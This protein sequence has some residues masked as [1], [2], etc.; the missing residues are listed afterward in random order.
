[1]RSPVPALKIAPAATSAPEAL[2][3]LRG[4]QAGVV[5]LR[6]RLIASFLAVSAA[7]WIVG[8]WR[9][10][11]WLLISVAAVNVAANGVAWACLRAGRFRPWQFWG[12]IVTD[13][14]LRG[15]FVAS[16][17]ANGYAW[18][19]L[20]AVG[21]AG[22][23]LGNPR[24]GRLDMLLGA[25]TYPLA[26]AAGYALAGLPVPWARVAG[27]DAFLLLFGWMSL[28]APTLYTLRL[29]RARDAAE[30]MAGGDFTVRLP[31]RTLDELGH[32]LRSVDRMAG[33]VGEVVRE[34]QAQARE[35]AAAS[36][37]LAAMA[38]EVEASAERVGAGTGRL[39][40]ESEH[41]ATLAGRGE[42]LASGLRERAE[43][44]RRRAALA[45]R[46]A[47]AMAERTEAQARG[48]EHTGA[49]LAD[50]GRDAEHHA[51]SMRALE[52]AGE[53][54]GGFAATIR[55]IAEQTNLLALNAAIEAARAGEH[56]RGFAVVAEEVRKLAEESASSAAEVA[57]TV[58]ETE[59]AIR[60]LRVRLD[61]AGRRM[62]DAAAS[63]E[64]GRGAFRMTADGLAEMIGFVRYLT[65]AADAQAAAT[66][67]MC[68]GMREVRE[69]AATGLDRSR[70]TAVATEQQ[71]ASMRQLA[72]TSQEMAATAAALHRAAGR[73]RIAQ[74]D[75]AASQPA[76]STDVAP[77]TA[78][79]TD[80]PSPA[81]A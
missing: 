41:T 9:P 8:A 60:E 66:D 35:I 40:S 53:R 24:A 18:L 62:G 6:W 72:A 52:A 10:A 79:W 46:S 42:S 21:G 15:G 45:E 44:L 80:V 69:L 50:L 43:E 71:V 63:A 58:A 25:V 13:A 65:E 61:D 36:D 51:D 4:H 20:Y 70:E 28:I 29:R 7:G 73:F 30:R 26:R 75:G 39:A 1:M 78:A 19:P 55:A 77:Q 68:G 74:A 49:L 12:M 33:S 23:S 67:E 22:Y 81:A 56:G 16:F 47:R 17:G 48:M 31:T 34:I 32:T 5:K 57:S 38:Q 27:E 54:V 3:A 64:E 59:R 2:D 14:L 76:D 11:V 37:Q